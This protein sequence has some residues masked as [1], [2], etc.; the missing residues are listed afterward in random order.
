MAEAQ[1]PGRSDAETL[2][3]EGWG[4]VVAVAGRLAQVMVAH[5][6]RENPA[7]HEA[8]GAAEA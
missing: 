6:L 2:G 4:D 7:L 3:V 1:A 5:D 8:R